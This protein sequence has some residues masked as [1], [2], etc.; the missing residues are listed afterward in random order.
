MSAPI[1]A[2]AHQG[3]S[4]FGRGL[5]ALFLRSLGWTLEGKLPEGTKAVVIA[6]PH[7]T[8][9][10]MPI[11]LAVAYAHGI[12]PSWLGKKELF[13]WPF[14]GFMRWLGGLPI[15]RGSRHNIVQQVVDVYRSTDRLYVVIPPSATRGRAKH[16]KSGFYHIARGAG[17]PVMATAL[18]YRR[19][20]G[21]IGP[22]F[23]PTGNMKA[24]MDILRAFYSK[25]VGKFPE[26]VT[27]VLLA[28]EADGAAPADPVAG[29]DA[30]MDES[31]ATPPIND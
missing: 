28:E 27:P 29:V 4:R 22:A 31:P 14:G 19:K 20:V 25:V 8:N 23:H 10:D 5:G 18:D 16:W 12:N 9:W 15:D 13:R 7:T 17:V 1:N 11:M 21:S 26:L 24:D 6:A 3:T 30:G 2:N